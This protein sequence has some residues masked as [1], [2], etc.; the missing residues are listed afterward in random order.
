[1]VLFSS[2]NG[3]EHIHIRSAG[4]SGVGSPGPFRG[5]KR[6]LYEG[7]IR[8]PFIVRWP[9]HVPAGKVNRS[10]V[11]S[12]VDFVPTL[13]AL[14]VVRLPEDYHSD[15]EN[16]LDVLLRADRPKRRPL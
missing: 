2:D 4:H 14:I 12:G 5:R 8:T 15:G 11:V 6:S 13:A 3:P 7:G 10:S 16:M 1:M 9:G